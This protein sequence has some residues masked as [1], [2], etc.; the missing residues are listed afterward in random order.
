MC[1]TTLDKKTKQYKKGY[2]IF[3]VIDG[4]IWPE[5]NG[6]RI[7]KQNEWITDTKDYHR[8]DRGEQTGDRHFPHPHPV[9]CDAAIR[10]HGT[11]WPYAA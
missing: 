6:Y 5:M 4:I 10:G 11:R 1:L 3:K 8:L 2:K 9:P 7:Y